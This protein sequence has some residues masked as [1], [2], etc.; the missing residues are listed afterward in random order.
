MTLVL[1]NADRNASK[2]E[3]VM[4]DSSYKILV[5]DIDT[6]VYRFLEEKFENEDVD[7]SYEQDGNQGLLRLYDEHW[8]ILIIEHHLSSSDGLDI[9]DQVCKRGE[10]PPTLMMS[11]QWDEKEAVN[12]LKLGV[13]DYINREYDKKLFAILLT[14]IN[15]IIRFR[16][17]ERDKKVAESQ[18]KNSES[19]F[20]S[21]VDTIQEGIAITDMNER[22]VYA[23]SA[24]E[25]IFGVK[26]G[27]LRGKS[28]S[29]FFRGDEFTK[30]EH[31][32]E[33]RMMGQSSKYQLLLTRPN[34][35]KR[36]IQVTVS[37]RYNSDGIVTGSFGVILDISERKKMEEMLSA[38]ESYLAKKVEEQTA[39]L[40]IAYEELRRANQLQDEFLA[41]MTHE[42]KTPLN[43]ILGMSEVLAEQLT[44]ILPPNQHKY[45]QRIIQSGHNL[46]TMIKDILDFTRIVGGK[47][48]LYKN[49]VDLKLMVEDTIMKVEPL[50]KLKDLSVSLATNISRSIITVDELRMQ[51]VLK[52][53]VDNAI[54]F[55][56]E[57]GKVLIQI[58]SVSQNGLTEMIILRI[59]DQGIGISS[60][61][62]TKLF[63]PFSQLKSGLNR[64]YDGTGLGLALAQ[65]IAELHGGK[66]TV[67]SVQGVGSTFSL[68]L[69]IE[70]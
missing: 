63:K 29:E 43:V 38:S 27:Q 14:N 60:E 15:R 58:D 22:F 59:E 21:L 45:L 1:L 18:F 32:T 7:I 24:A 26:Q 16:T 30:I 35:E 23:N 25:K 10:L 37:P 11:L 49:P 64:K 62:I 54:K 36:D 34:G 40:R 70:L 55:S 42:L 68:Y 47:F 52:I 50:I 44:D 53:L 2:R 28:L 17:M 20:Q 57:K 13:L 5:I 67:E 3:L 48:V 9:V 39:K 61:D 56:P 65:K 46:N 6:T 33:V 41:N 31:E 8:D 51:T 66:I 4:D 19:L 69:P 12:A